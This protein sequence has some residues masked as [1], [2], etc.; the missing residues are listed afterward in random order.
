[1]TRTSSPDADV[2]YL[3]DATDVANV[4][5]VSDAA[6]E[7][8]EGLPSMIGVV[9]C[10]GDGSGTFATFDVT[11]CST[12]SD[13]LSH[14]QTF[15]HPLGPGGGW[16]RVLV[17][18]PELVITNAP[19]SVGNTADA[20]I[21]VEVVVSPTNPNVLLVATTGTAILDHYVPSPT[22]PHFG[23]RLLDIQMTP[24][25]PAGAICRMPATSFY[26]T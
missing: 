20:V 15:C 16:L 2:Q 21:V 14:A 10:P 13:S 6:L 19:L 1:V 5:V 23:G 25:P 3:A 9:A 8:F 18:R 26:S 7:A 22:S 4:A 24:L 11:S 17:Q 12:S